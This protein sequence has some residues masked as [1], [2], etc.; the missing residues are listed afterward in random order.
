M[1]PT[2]GQQSP[3][4]LHRCGREASPGRDGSWRR[5]HSPVNQS[6]DLDS[7]TTVMNSADK[8][9]TNERIFT[10]LGVRDAPASFAGDVSQRVDHLAS[11]P[12]WEAARPLTLLDKSAFSQ[13]LRPLATKE[14]KQRFL[15]AAAQG[16][17]R[18]MKRLFS[19]GVGVNYVSPNQ[20]TA[21]LLAADAGHEQVVQWLIA[22]GASVDPVNAIRGLTPLS[23][24]IEKGHYAVFMCLLEAD[25]SLEIA[26]STSGKLPIHRAAGLQKDVRFCEELIKR[27]ANVN[28]ITPSRDTPLHFAVRSGAIDTVIKLLNAG[29]NADARTATGSSPAIIAALHYHWDHLKLLAINGADLEARDSEGMSAMTLL[30]QKGDRQKIAEIQQLC[31]IEKERK[32]LEEK[33]QALCESLRQEAAAKNSPAQRVLNYAR[34]EEMLLNELTA[35][36]ENDE[37]AQLQAALRQLLD[38]CNAKQQYAFTSKIAG[39]L[40]NWKEPEDFFRGRTDDSAHI[41]PGDPAIQQIQVYINHIQ[42]VYDEISKGRSGLPADNKRLTDI[43]DN[44]KK[45]FANYKTAL[46]NSSGEAQRNLIRGL[47]RVYGLPN[48]KNCLK[49]EHALQLLPAYGA[50]S[51]IIGC[52]HIVHSLNGMHWKLDPDSPGVEFQVASLYDILVGEGIAPSRIIKVSNWKDNH[53]VQVS[54]T[55]EGLDLEF[56]LCYHP[57]L[58]SKIDPYNFSALSILGRV[59]RP[60]DRKPNNMIGTFKVDSAGKIVSVHLSDIDSDESF[61]TPIVADR[62]NQDTHYAGVK[63]VLDFFPQMHQ[64]IHTDFRR[65]FLEH[66]PEEVVIRWLK[67]QLRFNDEHCAQAIERREMTEKELTWIH[68]P[69]K[70]VPG[71]A[72]R[73]VASI[74]HIQQ[75]MQANENLTHWQLFEGMEPTLAAYYKSIHENHPN[76]MDACVHLYESPSIESHLLRNSRA[77]Q[78][79]MVLQALAGETQSPSAYAENRSQSIED[80][81]CEMVNSIDYSQMRDEG[82]MQKVLSLVSTLP[83]LKSLRLVNCTIFKGNAVKY[84]GEELSNLITLSLVRCTNLTGDVLLDFLLRRPT[85]TVELSGYDKTLFNTDSFPKNRIRFIE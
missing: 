53:F 62:R 13:G 63:N 82:E 26:P 39:L 21:M 1:Q 33:F 77:F 60:N 85:V 75:A 79:H 68:L 28:A 76:P 51:V 43:L 31:R 55:V 16:D 9:T 14:D 11:A 42:R 69:L 6:T 73:V 4:N 2:Q 78:H 47:P 45:L 66:S 10:P 38:D 24:S 74:R 7:T 65:R 44:L 54:K 35:V 25:A 40:E 37:I 20:D 30:L 49:L 22:C 32:K 3:H 80:A 84:F 59:T 52:T 64:P 18:E 57:E 81:I 29:A 8:G 5:G 46:C 48:G 67:A 12:L 23:V 61:S 50:K 56:I 36:T 34:A 83:F 17:L 70:L 19:M 72:C 58:I 27:G 71:E 41:F 15:E